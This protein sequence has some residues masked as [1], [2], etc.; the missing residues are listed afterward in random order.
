MQLL[1]EEMQ[2]INGEMQI[3]ERNSTTKFNYSD[4][5]QVLRLLSNP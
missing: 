3:K 4:L 1:I 5:V 2:Y